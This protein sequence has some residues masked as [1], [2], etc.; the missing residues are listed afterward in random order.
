MEQYIYQSGRYIGIDSLSTNLSPV[1][2][3]HALTKHGLMRSDAART[4]V[5]ILL[6]IVSTIHN[7]SD[8]HAYVALHSWN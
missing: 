2:K 4:V 5:T 1:A 6:C 7:A 8:A 3:I